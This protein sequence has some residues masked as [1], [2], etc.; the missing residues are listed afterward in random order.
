M[1]YDRASISDPAF[2][3]AEE[4]TA[5]H[6]RKSIFDL[7]IE[8]DPGVTDELH[9]T[10]PGCSQRTNRGSRRLSITEAASTRLTKST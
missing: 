4:D 3:L 6:G 10:I 2:F 7:V 9:P 1:L 5:T 8:T